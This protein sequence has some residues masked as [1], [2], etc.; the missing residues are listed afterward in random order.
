MRPILGLAL[1]VLATAAVSGCTSSSSGPSFNVGPTYSGGDWGSAFAAMMFFVLA[2][3][4]ILCVLVVALAAFAVTGRGSG[5]QA[6]GI[7]LVILG[8]VWL[9]L[10]MGN[11]DLTPTLLAVL[12][13][14]IGVASLLPRQAQGTTDSAGRTIVVDEARR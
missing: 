1:L 12:M 8:A 5:S 4:A 7:V 11:L 2:I 6:A 9:M 3:V 10:I 13:I 14:A